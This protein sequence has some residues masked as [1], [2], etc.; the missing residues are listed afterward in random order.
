MRECLFGKALTHTRA[1]TYCM[2]SS[3]LV[4][5]LSV[6]PLQTSLTLVCVVAP[7]AVMCVCDAVLAAMLVCTP[8]MQ[9]N[10]MC[11]HVYVYRHPYTHKSTCSC[12]VLCYCI[13][14][15]DTK[16]KR[17]WRRLQNE[18]QRPWAPVLKRNDQCSWVKRKKRHVVLPFRELLRMT[19]RFL[20][21]F[22]IQVHFQGGARFH[23]CNLCPPSFLGKYFASLMRTAGPYNPNARGKASPDIPPMA[24][25]KAFRAGSMGKPVISRYAAAAPALPLHNITMGDCTAAGP[26]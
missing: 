24:T 6:L 12:I 5:C 8:G 25:Y 21:L 13:L 1:R 10:S 2:Q 16:G 17:Q 23:H 22:G 9:H 4:P 26:F 3:T 20:F 14:H 11:I 7:Y 15:I 19:F 18:L